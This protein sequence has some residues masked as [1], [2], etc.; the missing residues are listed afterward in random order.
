MGLLDVFK[1]KKE[2]EGYGQEDFGL[3]NDIN[4]GLNIPKDDLFKDES[5]SLNNSMN[6]NSFGDSSMGS[7]NKNNPFE[8]KGV[9]SGGFNQSGQQQPSQG[10]SGDFGKDLQ[11]IIAKLDALRA[12]V[13]SI[14]HRLDNLERA[15]PKK[16]W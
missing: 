5:G 6:D 2:S 3:N 1:K 13:Q 12:E 15:P 7:F 11:I 8:S 4:S 9:V 14:N 10:G 16:L